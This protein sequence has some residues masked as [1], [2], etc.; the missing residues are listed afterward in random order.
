MIM[1]WLLA[2]ASH[3]PVV[4]YPDCHPLRVQP[5]AY[6]MA[7]LYVVWWVTTRMVEERQRPYLLSIMIVVLILPYIA[8]AMMTR[9]LTT[10]CPDPLP[11]WMLTWRAS[12]HDYLQWMLVVYP[13]GVLHDG[14]L[15]GH[16]SQRFLSPVLLFLFYYLF[17]K[18]Y[19]GLLFP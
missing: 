17:L 6:I 15:A 19:F 14:L 5:T 7:A 16:N 8:G 13:L 11:T 10:Q 3:V 1:V 18:Y 9:N 12:V 4:T 2:A